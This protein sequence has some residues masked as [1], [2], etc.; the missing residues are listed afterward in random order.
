MITR[1]KSEQV[2]YRVGHKGVTEIIATEHGSENMTI[3][4]IK[5]GDAYT[6]VGL[7]HPHTVERAI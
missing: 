4:E 6:F 5:Y 2:E 1:I 3:Y 7:L